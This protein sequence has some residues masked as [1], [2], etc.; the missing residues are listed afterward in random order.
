M[1]VP[2]LRDYQDEARNAI[3]AGFFDLNARRQLVVLPTGCGKTVVFAQLKKHPDVKGWLE[4]FSEGQRKTLVIAHREELL[5]QAADKIHAANPDLIIEIEQAD[6]RAG[7]LAHVVVAS[8]QTLERRLDRFNPD[9]FRIVIIDEA[10]HCAARTYFKVLDHFGIAESPYID[11]TDLSAV[12]FKADQTKLFV[13]FTATPKRGDSVG[14]DAVFE[15]IAYSKDMMSMIEAG[16]LSRLR[17]LH[18]ST[19]TDLSKVSVRRGEFV[20]DELADAVNTTERNGAI[21][22]AWGEH[23]RDRKTLAFTVDVQHARDLAATYRA[24]GFVAEAISGEHSKDDRRELLRRFD[25]GDL[26]VLTN[27]ALLTEGFDQPDVA[28][29]VQARPTKSSLLYIQQTGRGTRLAPG[30][31][32]CLIL[33]CA[34]QSTRHSLITTA[35]L[36]GLPAGFDAQGRDLLLVKKRLDELEAERPGISFETVKN[37]RDVSVTVRAFDP[38]AKRELPPAFVNRAKFTWTPS[39][40]GISFKMR[41]PIGEDEDK[42]KV[43]ETIE[44]RKNQLEQWEV[45]I[46]T[47]LMPVAFKKLDHSIDAAETWIRQHRRDQ[48]GMLLSN[49]R[50]KQDLATDKQIAQLRRNRV[51]FDPATITKGE[52]SRLLDIASER[53]QRF[54]RR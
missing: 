12:D 51:P 25:K 49:V 42:R 18:V 22:T 39:S 34:D 37:W 29:I 52:A 54:S 23:A 5:H 36:A 11:R 30:K 38:F 46:N 19:K 3:A 48:I 44:L 47:T 7:P 1:T 6:R 45:A 21:V 4:G 10:H 13:G 28:C 24:A 15:R 16:Y 14:L 32:D 40:D 9:L 20:Q 31:A 26:Q 2:T 33:D 53:R 50:W 43:Y 35:D 41:Y 27:C 17:G 8:I